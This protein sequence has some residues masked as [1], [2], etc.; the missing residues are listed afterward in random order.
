MLRKLGNVIC[1]TYRVLPKPTLCF[2]E[3]VE[4]LHLFTNTAFQLS[5]L[6]R[7]AGDTRNPSF[8]G[9]IPNLTG[10]HAVLEL[11]L[12][13]C[14]EEVHGLGFVANSAFDPETISRRT[15]STDQVL[16]DAYFGGSLTLCNLIEGLA[17]YVYN[18]QRPVVEV[19]ACRQGEHLPS[20]LL[21]AVATSVDGS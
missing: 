11:E 10:C 2:G 8:D 16:I 19:V 13:N 4:V 3:S 17:T 21:V 20:L 18:A 5:D 15:R 6:L 1:A 14:G 9:G 7:C 12:L